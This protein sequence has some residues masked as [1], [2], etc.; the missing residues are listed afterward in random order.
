MKWISLKL[1]HKKYI[2]LT[3]IQ[4]EKAVRIKELCNSIDDFWMMLYAK[5]QRDYASGL[6]NY[7]T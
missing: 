3:G 5:N 7:V 2:L 1:V 4:V 6:R